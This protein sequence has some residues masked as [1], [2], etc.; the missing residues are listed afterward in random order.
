VLYILCRTRKPTLPADTSGLPS[1]LC[2]AEKVG[3]VVVETACV[4]ELPFL[5]G[6]EKIQGTPLFVLVEKEGA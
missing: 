2:I 4:I 6:R 1:F 3:G 5:K